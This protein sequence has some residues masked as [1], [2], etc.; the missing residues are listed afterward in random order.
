MGLNS[1]PA[2]AGNIGS[3]HYLQYATLGDVTNV[4]SRVCGVARAGEVVLSESTRARPKKSP[5][6]L[7]P[8]PPP[9]V[10]G[11]DEPLTLHR[12]E[13]EASSG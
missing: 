9:R 13:W 4:A 11:K 10:K 6:L 1:G 2:A 8:L 5:W 3:E 7:T 12:V